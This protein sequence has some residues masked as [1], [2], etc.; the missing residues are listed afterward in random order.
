MWASNVAI[1]DCCIFQPVLDGGGWGS[2]VAGGQAEPSA[3][4]QRGP[5]QQ[6]SAST[7]PSQHFTNI[8]SEISTAT[9]AKKIYVNK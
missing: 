5:W 8:I 7:T 2:H 3:Q 9:F 6:S 4:L 1:S